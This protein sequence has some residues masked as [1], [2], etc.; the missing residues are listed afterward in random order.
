MGIFDDISSG[1]RIGAGVFNVFDS[2]FNRSRSQV[3]TGRTTV[4]PSTQSVSLASTATPNPGSS[5]VPI[6]A[7]VNAAL[8]GFGRSAAMANVAG[9][10]VMAA[11]Y[12]PA[13][14]PMIQS[15]GFFSGDCPPSPIKRILTQARENSCES[16]TS[17]KIRESARVCGLELTA[18]RFGI[19][20]MDVCVIVT[21]T[22]S[23][24]SRGITASDLRRTRSTIRKIRSMQKDLS[25]VARRR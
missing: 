4:S 20:V 12:Q 13:S 22:R 15:R 25:A 19:D 5:R 18:E 3:P 9:G 24:R 17:K 23:R 8:P 1:L 21:N 14:V 11:A 10:R 16:V 6:A 7:P 2:V